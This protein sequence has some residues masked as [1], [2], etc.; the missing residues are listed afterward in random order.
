MCVDVLQSVSN[1]L[2][3]HRFVINNLWFQS[4]FNDLLWI[5]LILFIFRDNISELRFGGL[6]VSRFGNLATID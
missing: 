4:N 1:A 3:L 5:L 6:E 2:K